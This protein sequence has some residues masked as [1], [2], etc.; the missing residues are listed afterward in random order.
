MNV[1]SPW[2]EV[3]TNRSVVADSGSLAES[4]MT[5]RERENNALQEIA[6]KYLYL[7]FFFFFFP[8]F[9]GF[10]NVFNV[11]GGIHAYAMMAD[12]SIPTY[13]DFELMNS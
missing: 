13:W 1:V 5:Q 12:P 8:L 3:S 9:Q 6:P 10:R 2:S 4:N 11:A 7:S